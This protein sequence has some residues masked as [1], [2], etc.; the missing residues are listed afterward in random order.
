MQLDGL[1][2]QTRWMKTPRCCHGIS[3][4]LI[5][6]QWNSEVSDVSDSMLDEVAHVEGD[7]VD[8]E[9]LM[10]VSLKV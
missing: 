6:S 2:S 3:G 10:P 4:F 7:D 5:A 9:Y 1:K 8:V